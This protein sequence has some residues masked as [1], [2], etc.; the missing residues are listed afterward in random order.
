M[1]ASEALHDNCTYLLSEML[2]A[3]RRLKPPRTPLPPADARDALR[4]GATVTTSSHPDA[5]KNNLKKDTSN[6][7]ICKPYTN[8]EI[9]S[10]V[11]AKQNGAPPKRSYER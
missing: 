3:G 8:R 10:F 4:H 7:R 2:L 9:F 5:G 11:S 6:Q 1:C